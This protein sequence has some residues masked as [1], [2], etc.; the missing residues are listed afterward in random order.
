MKKR[1]Q[2]TIFVIIAVLVFVVIIGSFLMQQRISEDFYISNEI[3]PIYDIVSE[4]VNTVSLNAIYDI[5]ESGGHFQVPEKSNYMNFP[6]YFYEDE[7]YFIELSYI[8]S[9]IEKYIEAVLPFCVSNAASELKSY[10]ITFTKTNAT[11]EIK[12]DDNVYINVQF[13]FTIKKQEKSFYFDKPFD[14]VF[15]IRLY[16]IYLLASN[17]VEW[18][19]EEPRAL[20]VNCISDLSFFLGLYTITNN[21]FNKG[22]VFMIKDGE[23]PEYE[24]YSFFFVIKTK[25][26]E[27]YDPFEDLL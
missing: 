11:V 20:C 17:I 4:C 9:S 27:F 18:Q 10:E 14:N 21:D 24:D 22:T 8:E 13:P 6:Y 3:R 23:K 2:L 12:E 5:S 25:K 16:S 7:A 26:E 15:D 1:G 19:I